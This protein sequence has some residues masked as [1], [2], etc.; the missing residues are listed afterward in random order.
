[1]QIIGKILYNKELL[2][3]YFRMRIGFQGCVKEITPGQFFM[4]RVG[5]TYDPLLRRPM[6]IHRVLGDRKGIEI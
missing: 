1:M 6:G 4:V 3:D 2:P 5:E